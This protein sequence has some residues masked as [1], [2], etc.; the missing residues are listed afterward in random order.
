M[1]TDLEEFEEMVLA[2]IGKHDTGTKGFK[3]VTDAVLWLTSEF[4]LHQL[5]ILVRI[6]KDI[7]TAYRG[8]PPFV[9]KEKAENYQK[10]FIFCLRDA[11]RIFDEEFEKDSLNFM[12]NGRILSALMN[13]FDAHSR[14][15]Y[16]VPNMKNPTNFLNGDGSVTL[17]KRNIEELLEYY[18]TKRRPILYWIAHSNIL[19]EIPY[20]PENRER[21]ITQVKRRLPLAE[22]SVIKQYYLSW[23]KE[24]G[25]Q[26]TASGL[27]TD[28][29][30][31]CR[32]PTTIEEVFKELEALTPE[33]LFKNLLQSEP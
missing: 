7:E 2:Y 29:E 26:S 6:L 30:L 1:I 28:S 12:K 5:Y 27:L 33:G 16:G 25:I 24:V 18:Q 23:G 31:W 17:R 22:E 11:K 20:K 10:L 19:L 3:A 8:R 13:I 32:F 21:Y 9:L 15:A 4:N 14:L